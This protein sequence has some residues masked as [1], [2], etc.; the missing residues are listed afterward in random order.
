MPQ[1]KPQDDTQVNTAFF[2][3]EDAGVESEWEVVEEPAPQPKT[4][5]AE[6]PKHDPRAI[7][8]AESLGIS[9]ERAAQ[10]SPE[11]LEVAIE[12]AAEQV[13][14]REQI[15]NDALRARPQSRPEP[16]APAEDEF[17]WGEVEMEDDFGN[18]VVRKATEKD[19]GPSARLFKAQQQKLKDLE[20]HLADRAKRDAEAESL[21]YRDAADEAF[22]GLGESFAGIFGSGEVAADSD[23][24]FARSAVW[25]Q[26]AKAANAKG[27]KLT[28]K[29]WK[30][31]VD[32]TAKRMYGRV[33]QAK[34][35][36]GDEMPEA[37][38]YGSPVNRIAGVNGN[39]H[40]K[41][42]VNPRAEA[43]KTRRDPATGLFRSN[44]ELEHER[45]EAERQRYFF[46][47]TSER[48][49]S[50]RSPK[51]ATGRNAAI[52]YLDEEREALGGEPGGVEEY[53][54]SGQFVP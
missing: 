52:A 7:R 50:R 34:P 21:T 37:G 4:P 30:A 28:P 44:E 3:A 10:Y 12:T 25:D 5:K 41:P 54:E 32:Q 19:F 2:E 22:S 49:T 46:G 17:D 13:S 47:G 45:E 24:M 33:A 53:D 31:L 38:G 8:L 23:E 11:Q 27:Q 43:A 18:K 9:R 51:E 36:A 39:G 14:R 48:S 1:P 15:I 29:Q 42:P 16:E 26:A 35:P 20:K 40:A 6:A